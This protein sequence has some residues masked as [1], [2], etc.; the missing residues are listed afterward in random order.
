[1]GIMSTKFQQDHFTNSKDI[2]GKLLVT[3]SFL[4]KMATWRQLF[5]EWPTNYM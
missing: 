4:L 2:S 5:F 1:M 3:L